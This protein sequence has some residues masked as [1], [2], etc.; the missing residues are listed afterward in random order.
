MQRKVFAAILSVVVLLNFAGCGTSMYESQEKEVSE[1]NEGVSDAKKLFKDNKDIALNNEVAIVNMV[2]CNDITKESYSLL[3]I[4][5][6]LDRE[7]GESDARFMYRNMH[8][9]MENTSLD[10]YSEFLDWINGISEFTDK[11][12]DHEYLFFKPYVVSRGFYSSVSAK[13][14][15]QFIVIG[16]PNYGKS[17][18]ARIYWKDKKIHGIVLN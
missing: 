6:P 17:I 13:Y 16:V 3:N 4:E 12:G 10:T 5:E 18:K 7:E 14:M 11:N 9:L 2:T 15:T 8:T 1:Y